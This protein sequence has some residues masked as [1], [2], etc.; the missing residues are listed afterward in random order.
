M[1]VLLLTIYQRILTEMDKKSMWKDSLTLLLVSSSVVEHVEDTRTESL[2]SF[3]DWELSVLTLCLDL[4]TVAAFK[5][6]V[7]YSFLTL[8]LLLL[9]LSVRHGTH[10]VFIVPA[11]C[12]CYSVFYLACY[13]S[14][15]SHTCTVF[16][17][18]A[19]DKNNTVVLCTETVA[20]SQL[21]VMSVDP[22]IARAGRAV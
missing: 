1:R 19:R 6:Y 15:C 21:C 7:L 5:R 10:V 11:L 16:V 4:N 17:Q 20:D 13:T 22:S 8:N 2:V 18:W 14:C 9:C 12:E 3:K